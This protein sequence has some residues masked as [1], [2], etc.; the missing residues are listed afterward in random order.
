MLAKV[1]RALDLHV[2]DVG[3]GLHHAVAHVQSGL[4]AHL[5]FLHGDH[6]FFQADGGVFHLHFALQAAGVVLCRADRVQC[7]AQCGGK[8]GAVAALQRRWGDAAGLA[9]AVEGRCGGA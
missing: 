5:G 2:H 3:V 6:G 1:R 9:K 8:A 4:K 7:A